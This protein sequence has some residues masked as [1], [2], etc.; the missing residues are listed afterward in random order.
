M[1]T[2]ERH[3][4]K[5]FASDNAYR[6]HLQ[7]RRHREREQNPRQQPRHVSR[8][9]GLDPIDLA[10]E[11]SGSVSS[12]EEIET[13]LAVTRRRARPSDCLFCTARTGSISSALSHMAT[14]H[15]FFLPCQEQL[16]DLP[17][18]LAYLG[19]KVVVGNICLFCPGGGKEFGSLEAV[20]RHMIDK[21]H[22]KVAYD[23]EEDK[24]ELSDFYRFSDEAHG[25]SSDWE[26]VTGDDELDFDEAAQVR[27]S[28]VYSI[29][30]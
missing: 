14:V 13:R 11:S 30:C 9:S 20:R 22:C 6:S 4:S 23:S 7:S 29:W 28:Q 26:D 17:G 15:S 24:A 2:A 12:D 3:I 5:T 1:S 10:G 19:E 8:D 16:E 27:L 18:L 21:S 25:E